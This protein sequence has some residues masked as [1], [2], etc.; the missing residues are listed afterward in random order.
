MWLEPT[1]A[2]HITRLDTTPDVPGQVL[3]IAVQTS[4]ASG[5]TVTAIVSTG[6]QTVANSSATVGSSIRLSI[7]NPRLWSPDDPFL[8]DL[9]V[10]LSSGDVVTGYFGMRTVGTAVVN[11]FLRPV[12]NG[13]FFFQMGTLDHS[14]LSLAREQTLVLHNFAMTDYAAQGKSRDPNVVHLN[15]LK[16]HRAYYVALSRGHKAASTVIIQGF[17]AN[18]LTKGMNGWLRQ[19]FRE[20]E[21]LDEITRQRFEGKLPSSVHGIY[22]GQLITSYRKWKRSNADAPHLHPAIRRAS[23]AD[24]VFT[25]NYTAWHPTIRESKPAA[26]AS[27]KRKAAEAHPMESAPKKQATS[28]ASPGQGISVGTSRLRTL[29]Y[30]GL[31]WD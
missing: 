25:N 19:E 27:L 11:G 20:L 16:D 5:Q 26:S 22:R 18:K 3:N 30:P 15:N 21:I 28:S 4:G 1:N 13:R 9:R 31:I 23:E 12:L 10:T 7:P 29:P 24:D 14:V 8:Y 6:G 2:A 17:E